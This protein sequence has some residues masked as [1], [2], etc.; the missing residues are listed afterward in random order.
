MTIQ[1]WVAAAYNRSFVFDDL[2]RLASSTSG[3]GL[4]TTAQYQYDAMGNMLTQSIG[5]S[6]SPGARQA[7][8]SYIGTT[9][10][11]TTVTENGSSQ[12][13]IYDSGGNET[14][15][16]VT[17][18]YSPRNFMASMQ[19]SSGT[20]P[21]V[22]AY[23]Y[24]GRGVRVTRSERSVSAPAT[25]ALMRL[26]TYT[27]ELRLLS[28]TKD[29]TNW[30]A[31]H[32]DRN[33]KFDVV[34]FGDRPVAEIRPDLRTIPFYTYTDHLDT[35]YMQTDTAGNVLWMAEYEPYG[36]LWTM[37]VAPYDTQLL[38]F[39]GQEV[40]TTWEG[41]EERYNIFRWYRSGWGRYT[42]VDPAQPAYPSTAHNERPEISSKI[43]SYGY[44]G[45]APVNSIDPLGL[46]RCF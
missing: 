36:N 45:N 31:T 33:T 10:K 32:A 17:R 18:T 40:E 19:Q 27:P 14:A 26:Y 23:T 39:P 22:V 43:E 16:K 20:D 38:R 9:P 25:S 29:D 13:V 21:H 24:D 2:N 35:P 28:Y 42:Q 37:R 8:F 30:S 44:A 11:L 4:W 5:A 12:A 3:S 15:W 1:D 34:W 41:T 46:A 7:T 6:G